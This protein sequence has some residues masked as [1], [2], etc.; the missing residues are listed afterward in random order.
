MMDTISR[1]PCVLIG[2]GREEDG[3]IR[4]PDSRRVKVRRTRPL[5]TS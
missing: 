4:G 1:E 2:D 5:A 3:L